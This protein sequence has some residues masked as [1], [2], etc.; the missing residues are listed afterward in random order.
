MPLFPLFADLRDREVLVVGGGEVAT[1]KIQAL[2]RAG[3]QVMVYAHALAP[4][5]EAL[6]LQGRLQRLQ[7]ETI[8]PRW[9]QQAWLVV[10][11]TDDHALHR[12]LAGMAAAAKRW[13]NVVD[14]AEL[15]SY[16]VP[17]VI[18]RD[19]ITI[20]IS[21][22]GAAP[23]LARQLRERL[24]AELDPS[25]GALA[26][27]F[28][29]H[30]QRIRQRLPAMRERRDWFEHLLASEIPA[31]LR[32]GNT[33][34]AERAFET[35]LAEGGT[36][37]VA[38]WVALVG[39]GD[40]DPGLFALRGLRLLNQADLILVGDGVAQAIIDLARRDAAMH[41]LPQIDDLASVLSA[42]VLAGRRVV[43]LRPGSGFTDAGGRAVHAALV[44]LGHA[45]E[46]LPGAVWPDDTA[47]SLARVGQ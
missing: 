30:R 35:A 3:A 32:A 41:P 10:A 40:G 29:R 43:C 20:A 11:A 44:T 28:A 4:A 14:D 39:C 5:L 45:C 8:D 22:A 27:L 31:L 26:R 47:T 17:A 16:Q 24:E 18:D 15:S 37:R 23:M 2:L 42:H 36:V 13:I 33:D 7:G 21:S 46:T 12:E 25:L 6:A 1:R 9:I 38:G 19:P 34:A